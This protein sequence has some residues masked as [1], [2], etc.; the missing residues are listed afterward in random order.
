MASKEKIEAFLAEPRNVI[1][2]GIRS[3]GR[4]QL[5]PNWFAWDGE[6]FY[7]STTRTRA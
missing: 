4:P 5:T 1:V 7:V 3:D 2:G 6:R